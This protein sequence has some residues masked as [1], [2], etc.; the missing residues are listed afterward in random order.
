MKNRIAIVQ[1][2]RCNPIGC[3]NY[4]CARLCP[5]NMQKKDCITKD[6]LTNKAKIDEKLCTGC[7][8]CANRCPFEAISIIN[9]PEALEKPIHRF[10]M[11]GFHLYNL[12]TPIFGKV[13]GI[14]GR[15]G[16]G[17]TTAIKILAGMIKPNLGKEES[18]TYEELIQFFKG[19]ESQRFFEALKEGKI[20]VSYKPQ[21]IDLLPKTYKGKVKELLKKTDE[22]GKF[23]EIIEALSL[24]EIL[25][26]DISQ[27]SGGELQR[28]AIAATA[29]K[30]ANVYFF[31]EPS[32]YLDIKQRILVSNFIKKFADEKTAVIVIEHD[33]IILDHMTD[34]I[35]IMY[36]QEGAYGV[37]SLPKTSRNAINVYL[38]GYIKEEN[39]R[40]R[41]HPISFV[42]RREY[43]EQ[44][45]KRE[46]IEWTNIEKNLGDFKLNAKE[47]KIKAQESIGIVGE[48]GIGK[49]TFMRILSGELKTEKGN[50]SEN[51][52]ISYKPQYLK[53][54]SE[55]LTGEILKDAIKH[56]DHIF[57]P[58]ELHPLLTK[59]LNQLSGGELQRVSIAYCL[60]QK[61]DMFMLDEPSAYLDVEQRLLI[62]KI[63]REIAENT[64][65]SILVVDHDLMFIDY[66]SD[67]LIVFDGIPAKEGKANGP[68]EMQE[69]MNKFLQEINITLRRDQESNRPRI[70]K[71][72]SRLDREQKG[73]EKMYA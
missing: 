34:L 1:K 73:N 60:S 67:R 66:L 47:G 4:L 44:N 33:L 37:V 57:R 26:R 45:L 30:N 61:A 36:G 10:G 15:N 25:E 24:K 68:F 55:E 6:P 49:T 5:I 22:K 35:H 41:D 12:P 59:K 54:D 62:A 70:N 20:K 23:D 7:K 51:I 48:N 19:H 58:L 43:A 17:K 50:I 28:T 14:L 11:N 3:G 18:A 8:I 27:L 56:F 52:K 38:T 64:G 21:Q 29:L 16:I 13:V 40:F 32:S 72:G 71:P 2:D 31:D 69:G 53:S 63:I 46:I 9:L 65:A 42:S 39:M